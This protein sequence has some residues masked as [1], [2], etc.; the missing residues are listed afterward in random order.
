M[1]R[2]ILLTVPVAALGAAA[3][4]AAPKPAWRKAV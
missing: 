1:K 4:T 2:W 3:F